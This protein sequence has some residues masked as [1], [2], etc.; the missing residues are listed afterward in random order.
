MKAPIWQPGLTPEQERD[1]AYHERNLLALMLADGWYQD[2]DNNWPGWQR[3][4]SLFG[5]MM[6]FHIPDDFEV[7]SVPQIKPNWDGHSTR[8]KW[9]RVMV[10][11]GIKPEGYGTKTGEPQAGA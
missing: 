3:V 5:G 2:T 6:T 1:I 9:E 11:F 7:G 10:K 4:L 8:E